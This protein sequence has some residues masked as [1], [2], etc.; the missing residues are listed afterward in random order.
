MGDTEKNTTAETPDVSTGTTTSDW[1]LGFVTAIRGSLGRIA[2]AAKGGEPLSDAA[3]LR[4]RA[5]MLDAEEN[6]EK[7]G[8]AVETLGAKEPKPK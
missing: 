3:K 5:E 6:W 2:K 7:L 1:T 8:Q 4:V